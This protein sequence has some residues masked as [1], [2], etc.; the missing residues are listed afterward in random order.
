M[1]SR[2]VNYSMLY[3]LETIH[4]SSSENSVLVKH[5]SGCIMF[6]VTFGLIVA[7]I[8]R[9]FSGFLVGVGLC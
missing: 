9:I 8:L 5:A 1:Y 3:L 4:C 7:T 2:D 6:R